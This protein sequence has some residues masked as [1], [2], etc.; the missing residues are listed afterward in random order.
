MSAKPFAS[1]VSGPITPKA[2]FKLFSLSTSVFVSFKSKLIFSDLLIFNE[3][4]F[5][6][7]R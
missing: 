1:G 3:P 4:A 5:P 7:K 2:I 6:G